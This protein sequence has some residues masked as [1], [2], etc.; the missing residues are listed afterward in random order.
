MEKI[1]SLEE[2]DISGTAIRQPP[3]SIFLMKNLKEL[4]FR[5]CKGPPSS[6]SCS[7]RFPFNLMLSSLS[8]LCS[9]TKLDLSDCNIQEGA[10]PRDIC[11][12]SSLEELYLSKN[13]FVS[14]PAFFLRWKS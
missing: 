7:W 12:L 11:N 2:L 8:G 4:S 5:G 10:I 6:T 9:L 13:S 14:L 1:E 3:S